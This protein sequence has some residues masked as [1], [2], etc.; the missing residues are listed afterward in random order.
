[1]LIAALVFSGSSCATVK[2]EVVH[3]GNYYWGHEVETFHP[4]GSEKAFWV[5]GPDAVLQPLRNE[6]KK[7]GA[8]AGEPYRPIY[9]EI[10]ATLEEKPGDGFAADYDGVYRVTSVKKSSAVAPPNCN[11]K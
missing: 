1:M 6:V 8:A 11:A 10:V 7:Q 4:C 5:I 3:R 2:D 9:V